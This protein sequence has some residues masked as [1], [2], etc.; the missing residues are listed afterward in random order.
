MVAEEGIATTTP[1]DE[2][3]AS[4]Q[5]EHENFRAALDYLDAVDLVVGDEALNPQNPGPQLA[6]YLKRSQRVKFSGK[7]IN[8][9]LPFRSINR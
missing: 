3:L 4:C 1:V 5:A 2:W 9:R 6:K 7:Q 8:N